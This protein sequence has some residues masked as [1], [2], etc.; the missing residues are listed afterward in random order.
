MSPSEAPSVVCWHLCTVR[1]LGPVLGAVDA[2]ANAT[3]SRALIC[4]SQVG[5]LVQHNSEGSVGSSFECL[6]L[7]SF[8][9]TR[10]ST[11]QFGEKKDSWVIIDSIL[12]VQ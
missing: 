10:L 3:A 1:P 9:Q 6:I 12:C 11:A 2:P 4:V 8:F 7:G 5:S